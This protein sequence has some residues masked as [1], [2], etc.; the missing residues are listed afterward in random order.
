MVSHSMTV[1]EFVHSMSIAAFWHLALVPNICSPISPSSISAFGAKAG[2]LARFWYDLM[3][4]NS[5]SPVLGPAM[6][7]EMLRMQPLTQG[8]AKGAQLGQQIDL[9]IWLWWSKPFWDPI[10]R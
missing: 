9:L 4:Q 7:G 6:R 3:D 8:W 1:V 2:D 10:Y 5:P